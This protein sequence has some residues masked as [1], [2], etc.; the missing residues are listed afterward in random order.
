MINRLIAFFL[1]IFAFAFLVSP[2]FA[3]SSK[4]APKPSAA[5]T[6]TPQATPLPDAKNFNSYTEFW[7]ITAG[8][9]MGEPLYFL[10]TLK[11]NLRD[12]LY[13][14]D[15]KKGEYKLTLSEKRLVEA[16]K[17]YLEKRDYANG[18]E[19]LAQS[20]ARREE[21]LMYIKK[22]KNEGRLVDY[23]QGR[24]VSSFER[25]AVLLSKMEMALT[26]QEKDQVIDNESRLKK[27]LE[28][29]PQ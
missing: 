7:P 26:G 5:P 25:Q 4:A 18:R 1:I 28:N 23:S 29:L 21:A 17:L 9:V 11:E 12:F 20:Q 13:F 27:L 3:V 8:K 2:V 22:A 24:L 6:S 19:S 10:K 16:E 14:S 15:L